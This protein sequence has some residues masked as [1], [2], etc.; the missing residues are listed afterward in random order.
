MTDSTKQIHYRPLTGY[1]YRLAH[2]MTV[3]VPWLDAH[4]IETA[5][6]LISVHGGTLT[7]KANYCWD[8]ASGPTRDDRTNM[9]GSLYHDALYQ[10]LRDGL[11]KQSLR[12]HID[13]LF[14]DML[15]ED[16][17]GRVRL[18]YYSLIRRFGKL[19][20]GRQEAPNL[21]SAP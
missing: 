11:L 15:R 12:P 19:T 6:G 17:M 8:G 9:R 13:D 5:N 16:G 7:I 4:H 21:R 14:L 3:D 18:R 1:K 20:S 10:M 2:D